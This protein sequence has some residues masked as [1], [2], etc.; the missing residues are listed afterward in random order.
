MPAAKTAKKA[1][2]YTV[3]NPRGIPKGRHILRVGEERWYEGD[4]FDPPKGCD[5]KRL[6]RDGFIGEED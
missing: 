1:G 2:A 3:L 5:V 6:L 4:R